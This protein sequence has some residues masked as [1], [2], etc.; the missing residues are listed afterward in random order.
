MGCEAGSAAATSGV[1][2]GRR[3][4]DRCRSERR[5][6]EGDPV[7]W[8]AGMGRVWMSGWWCEEH[9]C[10]YGLPTVTRQGA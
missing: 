5:S 7:S 10:E 3:V 1:A 6:P 9:C 8:P 4:G 2:R